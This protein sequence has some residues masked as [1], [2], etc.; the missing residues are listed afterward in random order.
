MENPAQGRIVPKCP[1]DVP[2][3]DKHKGFSAF[4][5]SLKQLPTVPSVVVKLIDAA[6]ADDSGLQEIG[7]LIQSD[8]SLAA[9][10]LK[11]ANSPSFGFPGKVAT[12]ERATT[13]LG[14]DLVRSL[15]LSMAAP[16]LFRR[17][18]G[19]QGFT[20]TEFWHHSLSCALASE[21]LARQAGFPQPAEAFVAGLLHDLGK[22]LLYRWDPEAYERILLKAQEERKPLHRVE[23]EELGLTH[24]EAG[25]LLLEDWSFPP[26]L[27]E[28][29]LHH[30]RTPS[31]SPRNLRR[32]LSGI[33]L[34]ADSLCHLHRFGHSGSLQGELD[35]EQ[36]EEQTGLP[37]GRRKELAG[38]VFRRFEEVSTYFFGTRGST[39]EL[40]LSAMS[41]ANEELSRLYVELRAKTLEHERAQEALRLKEEQVHRL[42][43]IEAVG[44]LAGGIAHDFNNL[45][46]VIT[47][48]SDFLLEAVGHDPELQEHIQV[49][50]KAAEQAATLTRQLLAFGRKQVLEPRVL[51]LNQVIAEKM[52]FLNRLVGSHVK[53]VTNLGPE[54]Q[55]VKL[56]PV[57]LEQ[58]L[59]NLAVNAK[60]AMPKGG[61]LTIK[62]A[63]VELGEA[64]VARLV[65]MDP[66]RYVLLL[67][68]DT[69]CGMDE[70]TQQRI[71]E[72]FFTTKEK[73][74]GMGLA[75]VFG[76]VK[77]SGGYI[78][79]D[80]APGQGST[81]KIYFP[82]VEREARQPSRVRETVQVQ[83]GSETILVAEDEDE[84]RRLVCKVLEMKGYQVLAARHGAEALQI[85]QEYAGPIHLLLTDVIM[86]RLSGFDLGER[87]SSERPD[88]KILYMS[89]YAP[90]ALVHQR[91]PGPGI[92][93]L[94]KPFTPQELLLKLQG[95]LY[96]TAAS[97]APPAAQSPHP[98]PN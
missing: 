67:L 2:C 23:E 49:I 57:Q 25:G 4:L 75:T 24:A 95:V 61:T 48:Y 59:L 78:Y 84:I 7:R 73:G 51:D 60:E 40:F 14:L 87:L 37:A 35:S 38:E 90:E 22:L 58:V 31:P 89:A 27:V 10:V 44:K 92:S 70:E 15:A 80:S 77:Q 1:S 19:T 28:A 93:L 66:G 76:I 86:P 33:V 11:V 88:L 42:Q 46:T 13:L 20:L 53:V 82:P 56:D 30:H 98:T 72:P 18:E 12:V 52:H 69:G 63:N 68:Q 96:G 83:Q 43:R 85:G 39:P 94:R 97:G 5:K 54:L 36:L 62:T 81:F 74:T 71:F 6:G 9:R 16:Q 32:D 21:L 50:M 45:L 55:A 64:E 65:P 34:C 79:V 47:G 17:L 91:L 29:V 3:S 26:L 41:R 8:H